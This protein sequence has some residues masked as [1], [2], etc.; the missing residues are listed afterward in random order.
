[1]ELLVV[2]AIIGLL[3][4]LLLPAVQ[5][6]RESARRSQ[7]GNNLKQIGLGINVYTEAR[8]QLPPGGVV[9][10]LG[11][12][13]GSAWTVFI[14]PF[15]EQND[16]FNKMQFN[17][18]SGWGSS[19]ATN[20]QN[21]SRNLLIGSYRCPSTTAPMWNTATSSGASILNNNYVGI[22]GAASGL[23]A[24][25]T[26]TR[27]ANPGSAVGCCSGGMASGGGALFP[28]GAIGT[29]SFRD[30]TSN[31]MA[32]SE[33]NESLTI[34]V[35]G[36]ASTRYWGTGMQHGWQIGSGVGSPPPSNNGGDNRTFQ[37]TTIRYQINQRDWTGVI[38]DATGNCNLYGICDNIGTNIPL[39]S[40]HPGANTAFVDG[41]VR[42]LAD[43]TDL[44]V[45]ARLA[46][47]DDKQPTPSF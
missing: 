32:V 10:R 25:F 42:F 36:I 23:I 38:T 9:D 29:E 19:S 24:G 2:I 7:C 39:T 30:G 1:V 28:A 12:G 41:S 47:R 22:S 14:L 20:N 3:V 6:A 27:I 40:A 33:Q 26:E 35:N 11:G 16:L 17:G 31:T 46:T 37:M 21:V 45:L 18:G 4:G 34:L 8:K 43:S 44:G 15:I 13:W 5:A